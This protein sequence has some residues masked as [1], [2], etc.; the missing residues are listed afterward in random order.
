MAHTERGRP[1]VAHEPKRCNDIE[2]LQLRNSV[3]QL[4]DGPAGTIARIERAEA[5]HRPTPEY[6]GP[7]PAE[8]V[9][10]LLGV[11]QN[12]D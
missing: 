3:V 8:T 5:A 11:A 1:E 6:A 7:L 4:E 10:A 2:S 12:V 9:T